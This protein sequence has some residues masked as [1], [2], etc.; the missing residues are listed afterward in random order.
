MSEPP[1]AYRRKALAQ[2]LGVSIRTVDRLLAD[3]SLRYVRKLGTTLIL[4]DSV[5][6]LLGL[7]S[8]LPTDVALPVSPCLALSV[9]KRREPRKC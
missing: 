3:G 7:P 6:R 8:G 1:L 5:D 4:A 2:K 9:R